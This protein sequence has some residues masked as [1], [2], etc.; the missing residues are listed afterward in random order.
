MFKKYENKGL[1]G[2]ANLGNTCFVNTTVQCIS[3]IYELNDFLEKGTF[4]NRINKKP[5]SLLLLEWNKLRKM[6]WSENCTIQPGA[7]I[8]TIQKVSKIQ[9]KSLFTGFAQNDLPEFLIFLIDCFHTAISREVEM[10]IRGKIKTKTD[11]VAKKCFEMMK[12]I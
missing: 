1:T 5:D 4:E 7:F 11:V 8:S 2:L 12:N 6:M 3:H 9:N 10:T